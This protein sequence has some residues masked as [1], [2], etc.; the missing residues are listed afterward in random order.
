MDYLAAVEKQFERLEPKV[1]AF[2]PER[3]RFQRLRREAASLLGEFPHP[4]NRPPLF[5]LPIGVKDI[6][7]V[8]GFVTQAGSKLPPAILQGP[9]AKSVSIL[10]RAGALVLG[11]TVTT[12][13]AYFGPGPTRNPRNPEHTPGGS[14]SGSAAA[15]AAELCLMAFGTQ[16]IGSINRPA[17]YCGVVGFKPSRDRISREGVIPL[18]S[19]LD[20]IG[21]FVANVYDAE[22]IAGLLCYQWQVAV[23]SRKPVLGVPEGPYLEKASA[24]GL[25]HFRENCRQL[26]DAGF[27]IKQVP[28]MHDF[29]QI[30]VRHNAIVAAEAAMFHA[31]WYEEYGELYHEKT[32]ELIKRGQT[33]SSEE[34]SAA[35]EGRSKL[36][37]ELTHLMDEQGVDLWISP[38]AQGTAPKGLAS[39]GN[40][41]MN[42]PWT[43]SGLPTISIPSGQNQAGM[44][45]GLQVTGRWYGDEVMLYW[46]ADLEPFVGS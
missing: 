24:E 11:K 21:F 45:L 36:R 32:S 42:L 2:V 16:T 35:L 26:A 22:T 41:V 6:F 9:E 12:E 40:P 34:L 31:K 27:V 30:F 23:S 5:G 39:T 14:S 18:S 46:A 8:D 7:H 25:A 3:E 1:L 13:F 17:A 37:Q 29:E 19:S 20:H 43:Y 10:R 15:V 4:E 28:S 38:A 44:P 33:I